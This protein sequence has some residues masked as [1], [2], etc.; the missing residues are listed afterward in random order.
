LFFKPRVGA[1]RR[2]RGGSENTSHPLISAFV[3]MAQKDA[4]VLVVKAE[5]SHLIPSRT[6]KLSPPAP[7]I[8][9]PEPWESRSPPEQWCFFIGNLFLISEA[10]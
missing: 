5:G 6:Q 8:L 4:I 2:L 7:M 1:N 10:I 3:E 9:G